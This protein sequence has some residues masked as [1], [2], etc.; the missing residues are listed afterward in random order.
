[1]S[2]E[3]PH[4]SQ[5]SSALSGA[6]KRS[7]VTNPIRITVALIKGLRLKQ[8][9]KNLF[10]FAALLFSGQVF[11]PA[12]SL[13]VLL[14]FL[15]FT[16]VAGSIY[17]LNDLLDVEQDRLHPEKKKRPIASGELPVSLA[18]IAMLAL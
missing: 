3:L 16:V 11:N 18:W 14:A 2:S 10:V 13:P 9:T 1:M 15:L 4:S 7:T 8:A 12:K 17:L 6:Q 5:T